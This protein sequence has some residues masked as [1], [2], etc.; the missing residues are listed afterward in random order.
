MHP[1]SWQ[2]S[3]W[4]T[5]HTLCSSV[6]YS[7]QSIAWDHIPAFR[8]RW[9][10]VNVNTLYKNKTVNDDIINNRQHKCR[11]E[12]TFLDFS[13]SQPQLN[14]VVGNRQDQYLLPYVS[15]SKLMWDWQSKS[16]LHNGLS[17][18][19]GGLWSW[20]GL[21]G[22]R[23]LLTFLSFCLTHLGDQCSGSL[24]PIVCDL[25]VYMFLPSWHAF[26]AS[27]VV[28]SN[29]FCNSVKIYATVWL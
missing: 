27:P 6:S 7:H 4:P 21:F 2:H 1:C 18:S 29:S 23:P 28:G 10:E 20:F 19:A 24:L 17:T 25:R 12:S 5:P 3:S 11:T 14:E 15:C 22:G 9:K 8:W 13:S 26:I 16:H